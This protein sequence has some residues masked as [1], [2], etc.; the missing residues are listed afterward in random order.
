MASPSR[1]R[2]QKHINKIVAHLQG[3]LDKS[4]AAPVERFVR[5]L[6]DRASAQD[7]L[8]AGIADLSGAALGLW[9]FAAK[10][11]TCAAAISRWAADNETAVSRTSAMISEFRAAGSVDI[12]RLALA[13]RQ[14][15]SML[16]AR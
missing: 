7:L 9:R 14:V 16:A 5:L 10:R 8:E 12:A 13:N 3:R 15:R 6:F 11:K 2:T 4:E 1:A